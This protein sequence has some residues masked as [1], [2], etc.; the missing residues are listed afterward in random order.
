MF[1][2]IQN[3]T[4]QNN[5]NAKIT[6]INGKQGE[7]ETTYSLTPHSMLLINGK[8][9]C[10]S[11]FVSGVLHPCRLN[12]WHSSKKWLTEDKELSLFESARGETFWDYLNK[13][14]ES[15]ELSMF[16]EAMAANS[17]I[18][19]LALQECSHVFEGLE[20]LV[21]VGCGRGGFT[22]LIHEAFPNLKC[23][24]FNQ[25]QVICKL[26]GDENLKFVGGDMFKSIPPAY[27]VL[28]KVHSP[29]VIE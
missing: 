10:L 27:I 29:N 24:V 8:S 7:E 2:L 13:D 3:S 16:Q 4:I 28:L 14:F 21:D 11:P 12:M 1:I 25:P 17:Q 18:F 22:K 20:S 19:N 26:S 15:G 9:T 6:L 23:T 5:L